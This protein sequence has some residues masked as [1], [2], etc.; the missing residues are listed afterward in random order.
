MP[1]P[2]LTKLRSEV[3]NSTY[4]DEKEHIKRLI[5][6]I[7]LSPSQF[8]Q[9]KRSALELI[10]KIRNTKVSGTEGFIHEYSLS[11][12]EGV[13]IM[14]LAESLL[15]IPDKKTAQ[16]LVE[17]KLKGKNWKKHIGKSN[18]LFVNAST[19]GLLLTGKVISLSES[20]FSLN[21]LINKVGEPV[22]LSSLKRA[23]QMISGEF[24]MGNTI[25]TAL[26]NAKKYTKKGYKMS[27]DI[28]GESSR[29]E[30]QADFYY[31][32]YLKAIK[33][34]SSEKIKG[35]L[36][37]QNNLSVK[38]SAL[39]PKVLLRKK[40][41]LKKELLPRLK[42]ITQLSIDAGITPSFDAEES[43]RQ[44]I[45]LEILTDLISDKDFKDY[46][47]IGFV[48]QGYQK[49]AFAIIDYV[50]EL[51]KTL[52][53][54]IPVR[55]VKGAYWDSEIKHAQE[56]GL[57]NYPV[58]TKKEHTDTSYLACAQKMLKN[59][60]F[61]YPQFA[62]HNAHTIASIIEMA[63]IQKFEFQ[64]LHGMGGIIH[65]E[66][67]KKGFKC[68]VYAPVGDYKD[69][70]AYLM[71][72]LLENGANTSFVN[73]V[74]NKQMSN[75]DIVANPVEKSKR[76]LEDSSKIPL[77]SNIY[78]DERDNSLGYEM[79]MKSDLEAIEAK[80]TEHSNKSYVGCSLI[81]GKEVYAKKSEVIKVLS[82]ANNKIC[83]GEIYKADDNQLKT[84]LDVADRY[85]DKWA[86]TNVK[87]RAKLV[88]KF[89]DLLHENRFELYS[90]LIREAGKNIDDAISEVRE[91][92]DFT[93]YY[94]V[95]A[96]KLCSA[97]ITMPGYTGESNHLTLNPRGTFLCVSPWNFPLAIFTGQIIAALVTGN[98]ALAKAAE[99]TSLI[100][101]Y[102]IKLMHDAGIPVEAIQ[103]LVVGGRKISEVVVSDNRIRGVCFTGSTSTAQNINRT[104][105]ARDTAIV[106]FIAE[107]GGQ[108][109]MIVDSSALLEQA[110]DAIIQSAFGS[111]GQRCSALRVAYIQK[112]IYKPLVEMLKGAM[113]DLHIGDTSDL[114]VDFG[115]VISQDAK[116]ELQEHV[117]LF[118]KQIIDIHHSHK[119]SSLKKGSYF[120]PHIIAIDKISDLKKENFGPILHVISYEAKDLDKVIDEIN[121]T[122]FG[123]TF[124]L[125]TRIEDKI[126]YVAKHVK[127]GNFYANR[128]TIGAVVGTHP[129]GGENN[130][131]TGFKAGGPHYLLRFM[132][133]RTLTINTT[134]IGG[135][136]ELL[137]D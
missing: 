9:I 36:Y 91:A 29:T 115:A 80:L 75:D 69:L 50:I 99:N 85:F 66:V 126:Q 136:L 25:P 83:V 106:P 88:R 47:G 34:L 33:I 52:K 53:K 28:L 117:N 131:G 62:T 48:V 87:E 86:N 6:S 125:Q 8:A 15:R 5:A 103:L 124:G 3:L 113:Q 32:E 82:P 13:A 55:L 89:G 109:A 42:E 111:I 26:K 121:S 18:S 54:K 31:K 90:L 65:D 105:A 95:Q 2:K 97:P 100:A 43:F 57:K 19:W 10:K 123:L 108:N 130:S 41:R 114:S 77:P 44:D 129:F 37:D 128:S 94:S 60:E 1:E 58:F 76:G 49:R 70:L 30:A 120:A 11:N 112:E 133:E 132:T 17:D 22:I 98:T 16:E 56:F 46:H 96:E 102:T 93:Y 14:C 84:A 51:A 134:A 72:R 71:R 68:R 38:L 45:Y 81:D 67:V 78:G 63:G 40:D 92:I 127:A 27:F 21:K 20:K 24:I 110:T 4:L 74:S 116:K 59:I 61:L 12:E 118:K 23:I 35:D 135:N 64:K 137:R 73:L 79:G 119:D 122:G 104:L 107:T 39:H 7:T 101:T